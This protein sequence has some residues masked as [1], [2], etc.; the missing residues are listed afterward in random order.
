MI[1]A[2][3]R[4]LWNGLFRRS[5]IEK[6]IAEELQFHI[7]ARADDLSARGVGRDE[8]LRQARLEL[9]SVERY[10]EEMRQ[11]RGL[12]VLDELRG[13]LKYAMRG[14]RK[15]PMFSLAAILTLALGIGAN[16]LVFSVVRAVILRPLDYAK[17]EELVQLWESGKHSEGDWVSFPNFRDWARQA[18]SFTNIAA[19]TFDSTNLS[20]G[21]EAEA[22]LSLEVTAKFFDV[23]GVKPI[24]GRTFVEG[25]DQP[26]R[27]RTAV[28]SYALWQRRYAGDTNIAG[29]EVV[30]GGTPCTIV[31]VMPASFRFPTGP[32][33][34]ELWVA[35]SRRPDIEQR[36]SHNFWTIGRLKPDVTLSEARAEMATIAASLAREF[37]K[38]D[39]DVDISVAYL[40]D[41]VSREVR[42]A[43]WILLGSVGLLL[44]LACANIANLLL[45][46]AES[47]RREMAI[48]EAIGA[49][50]T[51]LTRQALTESV[52]LAFLGAAVGVGVVYAILVPLLK[53]APAEI[54]RIQQTTVDLPVL[55]FTSVITLAA[56]ILFGLAPAIAGA[57]PNVHDSLKRSGARATTER[58]SLVLRQL[59]IASQ[60][61]LAVI[62]LIGAT[63]LT[64]SLINVNRL[65]P[66]F[67]TDG[68]FTAILNLSGQARYADSAQQSAFFEEVLR[69]IRAV[70]GVES[71]AVANSVPLSGVNDQGSFAIEGRPLSELQRYGPYGPE[72]NR[73]K[74]SAGYFEAM[75]IQVVQGRALDEHDRADS[76]K[77]AVISDLAARTFWPNENPIGKRIAV[78][79]S[80][81]GQ[82]MW[83]EI[84][85]VVRATRHFGLE[86]AEK[87]EIYVPHT[88][89][90]QPF[91]M[92]VVR[93]QRDMDGV[94]R[95]C[96]TEI[97][98]V[99]PQQAGF[100]V[101]R[102]EELLSTSE[103]GRRFQ[104][105][106]LA[107]FAIV[108]AFL[109]AIGIYGVAAYTVTRRAREVGIRLALGAHPTEVIL[110]VLRQGMVTIAA[111]AIAG[112][113]AAIALSRLL[114]N[115]LFGVSPS[116]SPTFIGALLFVLLVG[117]LSIY[118]P[119]RA[120]SRVDPVI[121]L[122]EE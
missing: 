34:V 82:P 16:S 87:P 69:R 52:L 64:R 85:G 91:M 2:K 100:A 60:V 55:V 107:G 99:N 110:L 51:R 89:V 29:R 80:K 1:R 76:Q 119:A 39:K 8:A 101:M 104:T 113:F 88:Q 49:G 83:H 114:A 20:G 57:G 66:G 112:A 37:P 59:L 11:A 122:S 75:G 25:E 32:V 7:E 72:A 43:L 65:D 15:N 98:S 118:W 27:D 22:A 108:A 111:G 5:N 90:P 58:S 70:P 67:R 120:A 3:L 30:L 35:G 61:A 36:G 79:R 18:Q 117:V 46:R 68:L 97:S 31:G 62:L 78:R 115:L 28:V 17:P 77:V 47:R 102:I 63:L 21:K 116:D 109:A 42:P 105:F 96:R 38:D 92:L 33:P 81:D 13:D 41:R 93:V 6:V 9:G 12:R 23:L 40:Q 86:A 74:V 48:R 94:I 24:L 71:A 95:A 53:W 10:K 45:S 54:P 4:S 56:G 73:P 19:Y 106:L 14:L 121:V 44:L 84:V 26:G 50:R 103:S